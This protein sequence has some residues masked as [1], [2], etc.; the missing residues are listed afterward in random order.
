MRKCKTYEGDEGVGG[1]GGNCKEI[2][3]NKLRY[4]FTAN[5]R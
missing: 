4:T 5:G 1:R 3:V 2:E